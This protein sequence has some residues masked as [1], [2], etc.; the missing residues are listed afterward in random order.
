MLATEGHRV[1]VAEIEVALLELGGIKDAVV[2]EREDNPGDKYLVAYVV[3]HRQNAS[4]IE[5]R[6][7]YQLPNRM[8]IVHLNKNETDYLYQEIFAQQSYLKHG[9]RLPNGACVFDVGANIGLFTLFVNQQCPDA[10]IYAFEPIPPIFETLRINA[11]LY[12]SNVKLYPVGLSNTETTATFA[13]YPA[14][15]MMSGLSAYANAEQEVEVV[16]QFLRNEQQSRVPGSATLL[17]HAD[18]ILAGRFEGQ[19]YRCR[20]KRLSDVIQ[21]EAVERIDLLKVDVQRAELDVLGGLEAED[22]EKIQQIVMEVHD[23]EGQATEGRVEEIIALLESQKYQVVV[24]QY[25]LLKGTDRYALY[26]LRKDREIQASSKKEQDGVDQLA[27]VELDAPLLSNSDMRRFLKEKLPD[28]MVPSA[29]V[30]LSALPLAPNGKVDRRALPAPGHTF[31]E[32]ESPF[33]APRTPSESVIAAVWQNVLGVEKVGVHDNFFDLGGH[34]LL[35]AQVTAKLRKEGLHITLKDMMFLTLG[36]L[37]S[38]CEGQ[39]Q[40]P[41]RARPM[42]YIQNLA[43]TI[44][45]AIFHGKDEQNS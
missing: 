33:V 27:P 9:I 39:M 38:I 29:F 5:G 6:A 14:F 20:L 34:S 2:M 1:E 28:Y 22:W 12:G 11:D 8:A 24:D 44:K 4:T 43:H 42:R 18:E 15:S 37:A 31:P 32:R 25:E 23:L 10:R 30:Q 36:Q 21:E 26:A 41:K 40:S 13:Y 19:S 35:S 7:R 3:P 16:K 45:R 17:K